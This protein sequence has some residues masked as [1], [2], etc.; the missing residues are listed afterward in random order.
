MTL[1]P[2]LAFG[3]FLAMRPGVSGY[4]VGFSVFFCLLAT[5][6]NVV[7]YQPDLL[8]NNGIAIV[9]AMLVSSLAFAVIFPPQMP[10]LIDKIKGS[11]RA[12]VVLACRGELRGLNQ[13]FQ[14]STHDL[15]AQL[16]VL[17]TKRSRQHRDALRWML[18]T[19]EV[20][21]AA[22]TCATRP[23]TRLTPK[24]CTR[25]GAAASSR[26]MPISQRYSS[27]QGQALWRVRWRRWA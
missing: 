7:I 24:H 11:L 15:M 17:L 4:G 26:R 5:P 22:L 2:V 6:D 23:L 19:L 18:V 8:I 14:S 1:A 3:A 9:A 25:A 10:W 27:S 12:Q 20:G 21:H 13:Y 16:R